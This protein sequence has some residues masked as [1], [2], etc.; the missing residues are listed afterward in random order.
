MFYAMLKITTDKLISLIV[1]SKLTKH[2]YLL[3]KKVSYNKTSCNVIKSKDLS[4][5]ER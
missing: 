3:N 1:V 4:S 5:K 2:Q